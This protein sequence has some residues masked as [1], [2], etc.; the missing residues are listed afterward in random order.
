MNLGS[1]TISGSYWEDRDP[2]AFSQ[3]FQLSMEGEDGS[4]DPTNRERESTR[5]NES[6]DIRFSAIG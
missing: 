5:I 1:H 4:T 3:A 2:D 6:C